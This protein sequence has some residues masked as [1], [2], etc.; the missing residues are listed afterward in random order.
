[1]KESHQMNLI[2]L[3]I[4]TQEGHECKNTCLKL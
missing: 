4:S 1:M 2:C 3:L